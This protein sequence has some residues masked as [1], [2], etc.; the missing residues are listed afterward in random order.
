MRIRVVLD[1]T[2]RLVIEPDPVVVLAGEP[3]YWDFI[4]SIANAEISWLVYF[5][6][7]APFGPAFRAL[8]TQTVHSRPAVAGPVTNATHRGI[9]PS[10]TAEEPGDHKY[11]IRASDRTTKTTLADDDPLLKILA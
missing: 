6:H 5:E 1:R 7:S 11:G 3:I 4:S 10:V 8:S 9:S 2:H